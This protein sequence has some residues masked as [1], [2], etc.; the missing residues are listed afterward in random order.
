MLQL[1]FFANTVLCAFSTKLGDFSVWLNVPILILAGAVWFISNRRVAKSSIKVTLLLVSYLMLS[2]FIA[3]SGPCN[4]KFPKSI[5]T[6]LSLTLLILI[7]LE[8]ARRANS[9]DWSNLQKTAIISLLVAFSA[10]AVEVLVP[11]WFPHQGGYREEGKLS[12]LFQEPSEV[13]FTLFPCITILMVAEDRKTRISG[14]LA[15][16]GLLIFSRSSTLI[17]L[18]AAWIVYRLFIQKRFRQASMLM[19]ASAALIILAWTINYEVLVAPTLD[20][21][22]GVAA[23]SETTG[24]SSLI[25]VQGW[26]DAWENISR[27]HGLGLGFNMMGCHPLPDVPVR[28]I[29][30]LGGMEELN[31]EDGS[32]QFAKIAS[33]F[34]V[35]GIAFY[36]VIIWWWIRFEKRIHT[37]EDSAD[38]QAA[39]TQAVLMFCFLASSFIRGGSYFSGNLLLWLVAFGGAVKLNCRLGLSTPPTNKKISSR[40]GHKPPGAVECA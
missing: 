11:S 15:L 40:A 34:G 29:L 36:G 32:F 18:I 38:R 35:V 8:T 23:S 14:A 13:A 7:G 37:I 24:I 16:L 30:S 22:A 27:T 33:E 12:G 26:Q 3:I 9:I 10:F 31:A 21:L 28:T 6:A 2:L 19:V 17:A 4:D 25:Y 39:S 20:R 5:I 1:W